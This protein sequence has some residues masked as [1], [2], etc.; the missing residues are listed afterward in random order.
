MEEIDLGE[1]SRAASRNHR[2][3]RRCDFARATVMGFCNSAA[4]RDAARLIARCECRA[5]WR[6]FSRRLSGTPTR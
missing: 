1:V 3:W 6:A 5:G 2:S 4:Q